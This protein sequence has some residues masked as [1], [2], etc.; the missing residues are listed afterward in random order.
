L[1]RCDDAP[2]GRPCLEGYDAERLGPVGRDEHDIAA[3][4][5]S[6][7]VGD[8]ASV[9]SPRKAFDSREQLGK[10]MLLARE[11]ASQESYLHLHSRLACC[12]GGLH[13]FEM[14]LMP[15]DPPHQQ[16]LER[17]GLGVVSRSRIV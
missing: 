8:L 1:V 10:V 7:G 12:T 4:N 15:I 6:P 11:R 9:A 13:C 3:L 5:E 2:S 17:I 16:K 14:T